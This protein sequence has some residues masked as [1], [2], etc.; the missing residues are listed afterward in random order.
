MTEFVM[1]VKQHTTSTAS[2]KLTPLLFFPH[3]FAM[4]VVVL[5]LQKTL[6]LQRYVCG[7]GYGCGSS[8]YYTEHT[9]WIYL[10]LS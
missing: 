4:F 8:M 10:L 7:R 1:H 9:Q 2:V 3:R 6:L 5:K